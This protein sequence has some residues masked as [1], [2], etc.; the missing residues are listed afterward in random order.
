MSGA[1]IVV[2]IPALLEIWAKTAASL[3][4]LSTTALV[5]FSGGSLSAKAGDMLLSKGVKFSAAYGGTE[6]GVPSHL[7]DMF[8]DN[9]AT[10]VPRD[11]KDWPWMRLSDRMDVR[12]VDQGDGTYELQM[13]AGISIFGTNEK[14][15]LSVENLPDAKGHATFDLWEKHPTI[16]GLWRIV[17]RKDD[18]LVLTSGE[19]TV[20]IHM[21]GR[22]LYSS[23]VQGSLLFGQGSNQVGVITEPSAEHAIDPKDE[24]ALA[25]FRNKLWPILEEANKDAPT[26]SRLFKEMILVSD[27]AKPL[28]RA[29]KGTVMRNATIATYAKRS[30]HSVES[31]LKS[32]VIDA[33]VNWT[34]SGLTM[35]LQKHAEQINKGKKVHPETDLFEQGFDSLS[36]MFLRNQIIGALRSRLSTDSSAKQA[37]DGLT[38]DIG[39]VNPTLQHLAS[40]VVNLLSPGAPNGLCVGVSAKTI[41]AMINKYSANFPRASSGNT[42]RAGPVVLLTSST[43]SLGSYILYNMLKDSRVARVYAFNRKSSHRSSFDGQ[44]AAFEDKGLSID[45]LSTTKVVFLE[46][47]ANADSFDLPVELYSEV[48]SSVTHIIHS[49]W[50]L[51]FNLGLLS[52][53]PNIRATRQLVDFALTSKAGTGLKFIFTSSISVARSWKASDEPYPKEVVNDQNTAVGTRLGGYGEGK[54]AVEQILAKAAERGLNIKSSLTLGCMPDARDLVSWIP[55]DTVASAIMDVAFSN[56]EVL[57]ALNVAHPRPIEWSVMV[58]NIASALASDGSLPLPPVPFREWVR[59]LEKQDTTTKEDFETVPAIALLDFF[60]RITDTVES[61]NVEEENFEA[62]SIVRFT[63]NK[64]CSF[65]KIVSQV[66]S[67]GVQDARRWVAYWKGIGFM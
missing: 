44:K 66:D 11:P 34:T 40:A 24:T 27:L 10:R 61:A 20:P 65:G 7:F 56:A 23:M 13:L 45:L 59:K 19:K 58:K 50:R 55:V 64:L 9:K 29:A 14:H 57:L 32:D 21:E 36:A 12:W 43:G 31:S 51:D 38:Q 6:F 4:Y 1:T 18:V 39:Y 47:D 28:P 33:P 22:I 37:L 8:P 60:R 35:W 62:V 2:A 54:Y 30:M 3:E 63:T 41:S 67:L 17:G 16:E 53:E 26:F 49:A 48:H 46:G 25:E 42:H 15:Q 5:V 52:F